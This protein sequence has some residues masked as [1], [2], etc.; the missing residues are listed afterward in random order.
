MS[1]ARSDDFT[2]ATPNYA[3]GAGKL[4]AA[5]AFAC[6]SAAPDVDAVPG[7]NVACYWY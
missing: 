6:A 2:G 1:S 3:W 7:A 5:G 4:D